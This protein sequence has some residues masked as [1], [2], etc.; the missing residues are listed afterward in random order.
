[1]KK[2]SFDTLF[3]IAVLLLA[4]YFL[5]ILTIIAD[6]LENERY[7]FKTDSHEILDT[8]TGKLYYNYSG[9]LSEIE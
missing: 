8:K 7:Q 9:R 6:N 2:I 5:I 4:A 3:K 1:M